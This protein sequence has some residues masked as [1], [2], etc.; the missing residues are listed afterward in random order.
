MTQVL[1]TSRPTRTSS[2]GLLV[3]AFVLVSFNLRIAFAGP[4]PLMKVLG[5]GGAAG[6]VLTTLPP[7]CLGLFAAIGVMVRNRLGEERAL[8]AAGIVLVLGLAVRLMGTAGLFV[9]T[10][11]AS[12]GVAVANVITPVLVK[13]RFPMERIGAMM[14]VY[15]FVVSLGAAV[16][17][18]V[19]YPLYEAT[20]STTWA[21][22]IAL[23]P[24]VVALISLVPQLDRAPAQ[25]AAAP[26]WTWLLRDPLAWSVTGYFGMQS[27]VLYVVFA[28]LPSIYV[29]KGTDQTTGGFYLSICAMVLALGGFAGPALAARR[30]SQRRHLVLSAVLCFVGVLGILLAPLATAPLWLV[31]LGLGIGSGQTIPSMLYVLRTRD[32]HTAAALSTKSQTV[33]YLLGAAGPLLA[34]VLHAAAG[35][36]DAALIGLLVLMAINVALGLSAG[37]AKFIEN[38]PVAA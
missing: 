23:I 20:G 2:I 4:G 18:A 9:G 5:L 28:W 32:H 3:V 26:S 24:A 37:R 12:A 22:G 36:W 6:S 29:E 35:T 25:A 33:G 14:G 16:T 1:Q 31:L 13:K 10:I 17:A 8:F 30:Q 21:L 19:S 34:E 27:L 15:G 7:L 11:V 38:G